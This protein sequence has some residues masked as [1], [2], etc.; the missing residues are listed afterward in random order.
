MAEP[1][2]PNI[3]VEGIEPG[4]IAFTLTAAI[5]SPSVSTIFPE[6]TPAASMVNVNP[7]MLWPGC[8]VNVR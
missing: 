6:I 5:E 3:P 1:N 4:S 2:E 7:V 8:N